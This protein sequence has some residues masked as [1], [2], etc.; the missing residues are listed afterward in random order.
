MASAAKYLSNVAKS[1]KYVAVDSV[2]AYNPVITDMAE[3]NA[4]IFKSAYTSIRNS[5]NTVKRISKTIAKSQMGELAVE[6]KKNILEDL[7]SGNFYN[8]EREQ[9]AMNA[10]LMNSDM[11]FGDDDFSVDFG[12]DDMGFGDDDFSVDRST[13]AMMNMM[14]TVGEKSANAVNQVLV[15]TAEYQVEANRQSTIALLTQQTQMNT[16]L[17]NGLH[18]LND[19][20][21]NIITFNNEAMSVHIENS[22]LFYDT[23]K[24]QLN[25][26]TSVLKEMLEL[27]KSIFTPNKSSSSGTKIRPSD[28]FTSE[29]AI[30]LA[31]YFKYVQQN[32]KE[33]DMGMSDML[34]MLN[35]AG[36]LKQLA[37]N[38]IGLLLTG[39]VQ[40]II[41]NVLKESMKSFNEAIRGGIATGLMNLSKLE[42]SDNPVLSM[43]GSM[44]GVNPSKKNRLDTSKYNKEAVSWTGKDHKALIGI[45]DLVG[46]IYSTIS[47][48]EEKVYDYDQ[49]KYISKKQ[50]KRNFEAQQNM[51]V[52]QANQSLAPQIE[53]Q[54]SQVS[55]YNEKDRKQFLKDLE[56][57]MKKSF[58]R[59][60]YFNPKD[61]Y[62]NEAYYGLKGKNAKYNMDL[63]RK[64]YNNITPEKKLQA[65]YDL[66]E[67]LEAQ[68]S[69]MRNLE[70]A[71]DSVFLSLFDGSGDEVKGTKNKKK[72][73]KQKKIGKLKSGLMTPIFDISSQIDTTNSLLLA[74]LQSTSRMESNYGDRYSTSN[75][76]PRYQDATLA[77]FGRTSSA[78]NKGKKSKSTKQK[79]SKSSKSDDSDGGGHRRTKDDIERIA[80]NL[81]KELMSTSATGDR[82]GNKDSVLDGLKKNDPKLYKALIYKMGGDSHTREIRDIVNALDESYASGNISVDQLRYELN[83][84]KKADLKLYK[85]IMKQK[86]NKKK[87][88]RSSEVTGVGNANNTGYRKATMNYGE[89][90][91]LDPG[92]TERVKYKD[93]E[94]IRS[95]KDADTATGKIKALIGGTKYLLD[96]PAQVVS[97]VLKR[98]DRRLYETLFGMG[99]QDEYSIT[100][101]IMNG[102]DDWFDELKEKTSD[103]FE[104]ISDAISEVGIKDKVTSLFK[105]VF[106][107]SIDVWASE[108]K[109]AMFGT[110]D[111]TFG[112]GMAKVFSTGFKEMAAGVKNLFGFGK[113]KSDNVEEDPEYL[114]SMANGWRDI[115]SGTLN[116]KGKE[117]QDKID[118]YNNL[119]KAFNQAHR[120]KHGSIWNNNTKKQ[121][122]YDNYNDWDIENAASGMR[123][124][125]RTGVVAVSEGE[126]ILPPDFNPNNIRKREKNENTAIDKFKSVY[127]DI[128]IPNFASGTDNG[129][130]ETEDYN[131][132][133]KKKQGAIDLINYLNEQVQT[134]RMTIETMMEVLGR[135]KKS[136]PELFSQMGSAFRTIRH[137]VRKE[138]RFTHDDY[139]EGHENLAMRI[140]DE[141][142]NITKSILGT[143]AGKTVT[144]KLNKLVGEEGKEAAKDSIL[145]LHK[146]LPTMAAAGV[147]GAG[148]SLMLG[149]VGGPLLGGAVGASIGLINKSENIK[150]LLFG[151]LKEDENGNTKRDGSGLLSRD[152]VTNMNKYLPNMTKGAIGG[153]IASILPFVPGGPV[154]GLIMGSAVGF[155]RSNESM[156]NLFFGNEEN[157][158]KM[159]QRIQKMA[160]KM[161]IGAVSSALLGP[162]GLTT[163]LLIGAGLGFVSDTEKYKQIMFGN[164]GL[165]G[166]RYGGIVGFIKDALEVPING[167]KDLFEKTTDWLK[168]DILQPIKDALN[169]LTQQISN[170]VN[171]VGDK[172]HE[173]IKSHLVQPIGAMVNK[174]LQ[175]FQKLG[176]TIIGTILGAVRKVVASP[177]KL[178]GA[179]GNKLRE[180]QLGT[181]GA[182][183]NTSLKDRL[184]QRD[185]IDKKKGKF[186]GKI[187]SIFGTDF[188]SRGK[189]VSDTDA[190]RLDEYLN[191]A[192]QEELENFYRVQQSIDP[193]SGKAIK[194]KKLKRHFGKEL[195]LD[196]IL[197]AEVSGKFVS[198]RN[199]DK[200]RNAV[201][202]GDFDK[203]RELARSKFI[204]P[205]RSEMMV[206]WLNTKEKDY[207]KLKDVWM[208]SEAKLAELQE[209]TGIKNIASLAAGR[210]VKSAIKE[211]F[212]V[213][214]NTTLSEQLEQ[215]KAKIS[216]DRDEDENKYR[217]TVT[218]HLKTMADA[219]T[220]IAF[221]DSKEAKE[222][223]AQR[224]S[225]VYG[226][227]F[228]NEDYTPNFVMND[229]NS[230][231]DT[232]EEEENQDPST[233][234]S[235]VIDMIN[236]GDING[237]REL[238]NGRVRP[239]R[240]KSIAKRLY[241]KAKNAANVVKS[242]MTE[243][244]IVKMRVNAQG[245]EIPDERDSET[246]LTLA[247]RDDN[248]NTQK[249]L[250]Q[251]ISGLGDG[252]KNLFGKSD[253]GDDEHKKGILSS[254]LGI[255]KGALGFLKSKAGL[256]AL[257][258]GVAGLAG[259]EINVKRRDGEGN[260]LLDTE[261]NPITDTTTIGEAVSSAVHRVWMGEDGTGKTSGLCLK[262]K[263]LW[264]GDDLSGQ[265]N[266]LWHNIKTFATEHAGPA[267]RRGITWFITD[268]LPGLLETFVRTIPSLVG[269][270][271]KGV[272]SMLGDLL[273]SKFSGIPVI[274]KLFGGKDKSSDSRSGAYESGSNYNDTRYTMTMPDGST[275]TI[276]T[277]IINSTTGAAPK[278]SSQ[279]LSELNS[280]DLGLSSKSSTGTSSNIR[281]SSSSNTSTATSKTYSTPASTVGGNSISSV[282]SNTS[283]A[284]SRIASTPQVSTTQKSNA[285]G[286]ADYSGTKEEVMAS[287]AYQNI[288][289]NATK[290]KVVAQLVPIWN[291]PIDGYGTVGQL[292]NNNQELLCTLTDPN[293]GEQIP[294]TGAD[295]LNYPQ[296]ANLIGVDSA[297]TDQERTQNSEDMGYIQTTDK[298]SRA[299]G[300]AALVGTRGGSGL[301]V[302]RAA[303]N[304]AL[305]AAKKLV[306]GKG[307]V[308]RG[309]RGAIEGTRMINNIPSYITEGVSKVSGAI[310]EAGSVGKGIKNIATGINNKIQAAKTASA[311]ANEGKSIFERIFKGKEKKSFGQKLHESKVDRD[312]KKAQRAGKRQAKEALNQQIQNDLRSNNYG[313][314]LKF[315]KG[316]ATEAASEASEKAYTKATNALSSTVDDVAEG[317]AKGKGASKIA[318]VV[319]KAKKVATKFFKENKVIKKFTS[320]VNSLLKN[321]KVAEKKIG[322]L[323][324]K[325]SDN[326][327]NKFSNKIAKAGAKIVAKASAKLA[328]YIGSGGLVAVAFIV[329]DFTKGMMNADV[330]L[331]VEKPTAMERVI[332]GL[333]QAVCYNIFFGLIEPDTVIEAV[334]SL[335]EG[336]GVDMSNLRDRQEEVAEETA[337]WN[338]EHKTNLT[339]KEYL[340][341]DKLGTKIKNAWNSAMDKVKTSKVGKAVS[342]AVSTV[343][344]GIKGIGKGIASG[345][346][347]AWNGIKNIGSGIKNLF[348]GGGNDTEE[349]EEGTTYASTV[350]RVSALDTGIEEGSGVV[351]SDSYSVTGVDYST[352]TGDIDP[353][354]I[355]SGEGSIISTQNQQLIQ[356]SANEINAAIPGMVSKMKQNIAKYLGI[357]TNE[358]TKQGK[359][360]GTDRFNN[361]GGP[362]TLMKNIVKMWARVNSIVNPLV[363]MLPKNIFYAVKGLMGFLGGNF[364]LSE[365]EN[366]GYGED[367]ISSAIATN[368]GSGRNTSSA[369]SSVSLNNR[370]NEVTRGS[371]SALSKTLS[372]ITGT[373][374][375]SSSSGVKAST[376]GRET[377]LLGKVVSGAKTVAKTAL[378]YNPIT[379]P[380]TL[381]S[382]LF[383]KGGSGS[384]IPSGLPNA[385]PQPD[386]DETNFISQKYSSY[387]NKKFTVSGDK[388]RVTVKD[389]GCAPAVATMVI[390]SNAGYEPITMDQAIKDALEYKQPDGGVT[391]DYFVDEFSKHGINS[392]F[393]TNKHT[394]M[395]DKI[396][397]QIKRGK[398]IILMG[399]DPRNK[400]KKNSPFGPTDH[401][402]VA[403]GVSP[404]GNKIYINDPESRTPKIEYDTSSVLDKVKIG[405]IPTIKNKKKASNALLNKVKKL[406]S[407]YSG[408]GPTRLIYVGDSRM[409]GMSTSGVSNVQF[410]ASVSSG[411]SWLKQQEG[412]IERYVTSGGSNPVVVFNHGI[413]DLSNRVAYA[414]FY[415][416]LRQRKW[417]KKAK[418]YFLS[419]N[420]IKRPCTSVSNADISSFNNYMSSRY[421]MFDGY[422]DTYS[423][424]INTDFGAAQDGLHYTNT[425]YK[426]IHDQIVSVLNGGRVSKNGP[427]GSSRSGSNSSSSPGN[428][429]G[430]KNGTKGKDSG[431]SGSSS[432]DSSSSSSSNSEE[433]DENR[434]LTPMEY[435]ENLDGNIKGINGF[436]STIDALAAAYGLTV[437]TSGSGGSSDYDEDSDGGSGSSHYSKDG[438]SGNV[439]SDKKIAEKQIKVIAQAKSIEGKNRYG[440][441]FGQFPY[442]RSI[443]DGGGDCSAFA[444]W[445]YQKA[446]GADI[447]DPTTGQEACGNTYFVDQPHQSRMPDEAD[448]QLGDIILYGGGA[449]RH[450]E[451]Y[452]GDG[453]TI[454]HG[455]STSS[456]FGVDSAGLGIGPFVAPISNQ[457]NPWSVKRLNEFKS[458]GSSHYSA[459]SD[460]FDEE[461]EETTDSKKNNKDKKSKKN[462]KSDKN[463]SK[464]GKGSGLP[465]FVSQLDSKY[466]N[467]QFGDETIAEAGCAPV[468]ATMA[469]SAYAKDTQKVPSLRN[470]VKRAVK[471]KSEGEGVPASFFVDEF[472]RSG[473]ST[474]VMRDIDNIY[475]SLI[476]NK[477]VVLLGQD[478]TNKSKRKSPFGPNG[479]YVL[480]TGISPDRKTVYVHDPEAK[481]GFIPYKASAIAK[482]ITVGIAPILKG[483]NKKADTLLRSLRSA[484]GDVK[485]NA[486]KKDNSKVKTASNCKYGP[487][488]PQYKCWVAIRQAGYSEV[489]AAAGLG[490]IEWESGFNPV[491]ASYDGGFGIIQWTGSE[492][493]KLRAAAAAEGADVNSIDFQC[494][495]MHTQLDDPSRWNAP[496]SGNYDG[497]KYTYDDWAKA[498]NEADIDKATMAWMTCYERPSLD[499]GTNH[500]DKRKESARGYYKEFTG[501][502]VSAASSSGSNSSSDSDSNGNK[503][504]GNN[505]PKVIEMISMFD[506]LAEKYGLL[507]EVPEVANESDDDSSGSGDS[508]STKVSGNSDKA[509]VWNY[510]D[511]KGIPD[512]GKAGLMGNLQAESGIQ[513]NNAENNYEH[514][515]GGDVE[516][517]EKIDNGK[518]DL[519]LFKHPWGDGESVCGYGLAQWT[520]PDRKAGL[521]GKTRAQNKSIADPKGQM[522]WLWE[523]LNSPGYAPTLN[524]MK[525]GSIDEAADAGLTNFERPADQSQAVIDT[526]RTYAHAIYDELHG[527]NTRSDSDENDSSSSSSSSSSIGSSSSGS[528]N[529]SSSGPSS[530]SGSSSSSK[531]KK[532]SNS[533]S[534]SGT[535]KKVFG[536]TDKY[537]REYTTSSAEELKKIIQRVTANYNKNVKVSSSNTLTGQKSGSTS[538]SSSSRRKTTSGL[539]RKHSNSGKGSGLVDFKP[540]TSFSNTNK[541]S[542]I[543]MPI[544][545]G[546]GKG[547]LSG[548]TIESIVDDTI[549]SRSIYKQSNLTVQN[550]TRV[551]SSSTD[552]KQLEAL[553]Q[554]L[555]KLL[556]QV[557]SNTSSISNISELMIKI[558]DIQNK[559]I[560]SGTGDKNE[561][562][563]DLLQTKALVLN[564]IKRSNDTQSTDVIDQL[565]KNMESLAIQ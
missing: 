476:H 180:H 458:S 462:D 282:S 199:A 410:I 432:T 304:I 504:G 239:S 298:F 196:T 480:A 416:T 503:S 526:R 43:I 201:L 49:G 163:N 32:A 411:L 335:L 441:G 246:R 351:T 423:T 206:K 434:T 539:Q 454:G 232:T 460:S 303:N 255:G 44:F 262:I 331:G 192:S 84:L 9:K 553:L 474:A 531:S 501:L 363:N 33:Q 560:S 297:L 203:A 154:A 264:L 564:S 293:T 198:K 182:A 353:E 484:L 40:S 214:A 515:T 356:R 170:M 487:D 12:D 183:S 288:V 429:K 489:S 450:V 467:I 494:S 342:G 296:T 101:K 452:H 2:K 389:A 139:E 565:M 421:R 554:V 341:K 391:A 349:S 360:I 510:L 538:S 145:N 225:K 455:G 399:N 381:L 324:L 116:A 227:D 325:L 281:P 463:K 405:V 187:D 226:T 404:D 76:E 473:Y 253:D 257:L 302:M 99:T 508:S 485:G 58:D 364:N 292:L 92:V 83:E 491:A 362:R 166:K 305:T 85:D 150:R 122:K 483:A 347:G 308:A 193:T 224:L 422:I 400:S 397:N 266:G 559:L 435:L 68:N 161:A 119:I 446:L 111:V 186:R 459:D 278:S 220:C 457:G 179:L 306:R 13:S 175:P 249:T 479:H 514:I 379:A 87:K 287:L 148:L 366:Y 323:L 223:K 259:T 492:Q 530:S 36:G 243:H 407:N 274:G 367:D 408:K 527:S 81:Y 4:E 451:L 563:K 125:S 499:P 54:L 277:N 211:R 10:S 205:D 230:T 127:G 115:T 322:G 197:A 24:E 398:K 562:Q 242:T 221:P 439:S 319:A 229:P 144:E 301:R 378:K 6:L 534:S 406:L 541:N 42:F 430:S 394:N 392:A 333:V 456:P 51:Y 69:Y 545:F 244:G 123:R 340:A 284:T 395:K 30:N 477:P 482:G 158:G 313:K 141:L 377:S 56:T 1:V 8:K 279:A 126:M 312:L 159:K 124:V 129:K 38:P 268:A 300:R 47:G 233:T 265:T 352:G 240:F 359:N 273:T 517:T 39:T 370:I 31:D 222:L 310:H 263:E 131:S 137:K 217:K 228:G 153:A 213:D 120:A 46:K 50:I 393:I 73:G 189:R 533:S 41:P 412:R 314:D 497:Y 34:E 74:I 418:M 236:A 247:R 237:A 162:F 210:T 61:K 26:Q 424:M 550:P 540:I 472:E 537:G 326:L 376:T 493:D 309:L 133:S 215:E 386:P 286:T 535:G 315:G 500:M 231:K 478:A 339:S 290:R 521:W 94:F 561:I 17:N 447:G 291:T 374:T 551:Y 520:M 142:G 86:A 355:V 23:T 436:L 317:A 453:T 507:D 147:T 178:M 109:K 219:L 65:N 443:D 174:I 373:P 532:K 330:N 358:L 185:E 329:Y 48:T 113:K 552:T 260:V 164:E 90:I 248:T 165:D 519:E 82:I 134:G 371:N 112:E 332:S 542:R 71:G 409:V 437:L 135:Y 77:D 511:D 365:G 216:K 64:I 60:E 512:A 103:T 110:E 45:H 188:S 18:A 438:I 62:M 114:Y 357:D 280:L 294:V 536:W 396:V 328:T 7:K 346:K 420:P 383:G 518:V 132:K 448:L 118:H 428:N 234:I 486:T 546:K 516:Y 502:E 261:G 403:T 496:L 382:K 522:D 63:I 156:R 431:T 258:G 171:W 172:I 495:Y 140:T 80:N 155:A 385:G 250:L 254:L 108:F 465:D 194:E 89:E 380:I 37:S 557:V 55:F 544:D 252:L 372:A 95:L 152:L 388:D 413:N 558:L 445:A 299:I 107:V 96:A 21:G 509:K 15:K 67:A 444:H 513:F 212:G 369:L 505:E 417:M 548:S 57:V 75:D 245:E 348:T 106:G 208:V 143:N 543:N 5:R 387:A 320:A 202:N 238:A 471:Y 102:F 19:N 272:I 307:I 177:F 78:R 97:S 461:D 11:G 433:K 523:E 190:A 415:T 16:M 59:G 184:R 149:L 35:D 528:S 168:D 466:K 368:L 72:K 70:E 316:T 117:K 337:K 169:P 481:K 442:T 283:T 207:N 414:Q 121:K 138:N 235:A 555:I 440:W 130:G 22:R 146:Y 547:T 321:K 218:D 20:L 375:R 53:Q 556:S 350:E 354:K 66:I 29:G 160:P 25:E 269:A 334:V 344:K 506:D 271:G 98:A 402:V 191:S 361:T 469:Q 419:V 524:A 209:K 401:Y 14:D 136:D 267:I 3:S 275:G 425:T 470:I 475:T 384:G 128:D 270:V 27:Q 200:I 295:I 91:N 204:N 390:N 241:N 498:T 490:N 256:I 549:A 529:G 289:D 104:K 52:R 176:N 343:G 426:W 449:S 464:G 488:T 173:S 336:L 157:A 468:V 100:G 79:K 88:Y 338:E 251:K 427:L 195:G 327:V 318:D 93:S 151:D 285:S 345:A 525:T 167:L 276:D 105:N 311:A 181:I 28:I